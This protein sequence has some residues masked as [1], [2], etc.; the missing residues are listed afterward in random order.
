M[1]AAGD[2][3]AAVPEITALDLNPVLATPTGAVAVDWKITLTTPS[4][5]HGRARCNVT[6]LARPV[7]PRGMDAEVLF[8]RHFEALW[9]HDG[10]AG[11]PADDGVGLHGA[12]GVTITPGDHICAFY[13]G[14]G[15][16]DAV[17]VPFLREGILAGDKTICVMDDP[18]TEPVVG[19]LSAE[20][21]VER[22][23]RTGQF[24][25]LD[26]DHAYLPGGC[27]AVQRMLDFWEQGFHPAEAEQG[28][29]SCGPCGEMT[30]AL[31]ALPGVGAAGQPT[32][33]SS[34]SSC[35]GTR[36]PCC[37]ASTTWSGSPTAS[38]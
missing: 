29:A 10:L 9:T 8:A 7:P 32:R 26:S 37:C 24:E 11:P 20:L 23:M 17:L 15:Q 13:R 5:A 33:P 3:L 14:R 16:R 1:V 6:R 36:R 19:P 38:C 28:Y 27:F 22:S 34:T 30:W 2:L 4:L 12:P 25:L 35:R 21:D 31:R 18:D